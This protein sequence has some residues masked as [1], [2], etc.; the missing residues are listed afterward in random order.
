MPESAPVRYTLSEPLSA[1][2]LRE[3]PGSSL[4]SPTGTLVSIPVGAI[5]EL[6]GA[7]AKSGLVNVHWNDEVFSVFYEDIAKARS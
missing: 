4:R 7:V 3:H 1:V 2:K 5:V 6:E